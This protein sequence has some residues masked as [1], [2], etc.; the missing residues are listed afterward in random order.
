VSIKI[1]EILLVLKYYIIFRPIFTIENETSS[2]NNFIL[3]YIE[4]ILQI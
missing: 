1:K 3:M 2:V 4:N